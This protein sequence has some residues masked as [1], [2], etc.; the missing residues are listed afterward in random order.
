MDTDNKKT[1]A[2]AAFVSERSARSETGS[3]FESFVAE[4][5]WSGSTIKLIAVITMLID[6]IGA[7]IVENFAVQYPEGRLFGLDYDGLYKLDMILRGIGRIAFPIFCFLLVEGFFK[8][9]S[10]WK[11]LGRLLI[12]GV[13][14]EVPFDLCFFRSALYTPY[15][16]VYFTLALGVLMMI[17]LERIKLFDSYR[18]G[19]GGSRTLRIILA[20]LTLIAFA[21]VAQIFMTDYYM[22]GIITIF[23]LYTFK[24]TRLGTCAAHALSCILVLSELPA[25][26]G[27]IPIALYNGKRGFKM[28]YFFYLFY[29][30]HLMVLWGISRMLGIS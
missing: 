26:A 17:C 10:V 4:H 7:G 9:R 22:L 12:F 8:T 28:K 6:H 29:P 30:A 1:T 3:G 25:L 23:L 18:L 20:S 19:P 14:S 13:I 27:V 16:N 2:D 15:Q 11:Y 21:I 5:G 24:K